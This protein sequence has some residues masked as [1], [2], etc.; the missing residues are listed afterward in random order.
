MITSLANYT[1]LYLRVCTKKL[2]F[3]FLN[4]TD[5]IALTAHRT[6]S[7]VIR[8]C[9]RDDVASLR[10]SAIV[11]FIHCLVLFQ[12][13]KTANRSDMTEKLLTGM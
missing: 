12:P 6:I 1:G 9:Q 7:L 10:L 8:H 11:S 3:L 5:E 4:Q 2:I 13:K